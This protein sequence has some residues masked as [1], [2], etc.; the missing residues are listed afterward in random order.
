MAH[1][2]RVFDACVAVS[3]AVPQA[4]AGAGLP[5][6]LAAVL[7]SV[8]LAWLAGVC[9]RRRAPPPKADPLG[10][11]K[12]DVAALAA[13]VVHLAELHVRVEAEL[14]YLRY[15]TNGFVLSSSSY[16]R[17][18][19]GDKTF[20]YTISRWGCALHLDADC[21]ELVQQIQDAERARRCA[22][23]I[24]L[25]LDVV[26]IV[27]AM[28]DMCLQCAGDIPRK[29]VSEARQRSFGGR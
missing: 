7:L 28:S 10:E 2:P 27:C 12:G 13:A 6:I 22:K 23:I 4:A 5:A 24:V 17:C 15:R 25:P 14:R 20:Y 21:R 19:R 16:R 29:L 8:A 9:L 18:L 26:A 3:Q 11:I 1:Y